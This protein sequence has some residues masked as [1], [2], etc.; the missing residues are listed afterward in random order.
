MPRIELVGERFGRL[1]VKAYSH[2]VDGRCYWVCQCDCGGAAYCTTN[3]LTSGRARSCGC[4]RSELSA[5]RTRARTKHGH[6]R[7]HEVTGEYRS[8]TCMKSRCLHPSNPKF[9]IYGGRGVTVCARWMHSFEN[10]LTDMGPKPTR[11]HTIDRIDPH[12]NYEPANCRW[13]TPLEQRHNRRGHK[14]AEVTGAIYP[15]SK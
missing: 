5:A 13:A 1:T 9:S 15:E 7:D 8:W 2:T 6:S 12:G 4:L 11:K 14:G 10:F 3:K